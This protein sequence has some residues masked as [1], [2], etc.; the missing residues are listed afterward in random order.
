[1]QVIHRRYLSTALPSLQRFGLS[2]Q[3][4]L[5]SA[6][7]ADNDYEEGCS[8]ICTKTQIPRQTPGAHFTH[9]CLEAVSTPSLVHASHSVA[10][11]IGLDHAD[12]ESDE[13]VAAVSGNKFL[14]GLDC[15]YATVYGCHSH[16]NWLGQL[17]DGRAIS[18]GEIVSPVDHQRY[19]L[20]LK[21]AG[22]TPYSRGFDGRA[23]LRSSIREFLASEAMYHLGVKTTRALSVVSTADQV[24]RKWYKG[25]GNDA[26]INETVAVLCRVSSSFFRFSHVEYFA[27]KKEPKLLMQVIDHIIDREYP[28]LRSPLL[29]KA[30]VYVELFRDIARKSMKLVT[31]WNRIGYCHGNMNSDNMHIAG[32]T[33]DYGPFGWM[34]MYSP[35]YQPYTADKNTGGRFSFQ[36][37]A[38]AMH[39]NLEILGECME[40]AV[41]AVCREQ[42]DVYAAADIY[43]LTDRINTIAKQDVLQHYAESYE[44]MI[45]EKLGL[46]MDFTPEVYQVWRQ[47]EHLMESSFADYTILFRCLATV[48]EKGANGTYAVD[49]IRTALYYDIVLDKPNNITKEGILFTEWIDWF[50]RYSKLREMDKLGG[51]PASRAARMNSKNPKYI[52]RNWMAAMAYELADKGDY[53]L[54]QELAK[55]L[56][57]PYGEGSAEDHDKWFVKTPPWAVNRPGIAYLSCSS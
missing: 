5:L 43:T 14:P 2:A 25:D 4:T 41:R 17:G 8:R 55:L 50:D 18:I 3:N 37:Q 42:P 10:D 44:C 39:V 26:V 27:K 53:T 30:E 6:L 28:H 15:G 23:V 13:F 12:L 49:I 7:T 22:K 19:E 56:E 29:S 35:S 21:G 32:L 48:V 1:M 57:N 54:V 46:T 11:L 38:A 52:L 33:L 24:S 20:Q 47:L 9:V 45:L 51:S 34:E 31:E 36:H 16:G 40:E